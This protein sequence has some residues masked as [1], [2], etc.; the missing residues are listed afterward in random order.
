MVV[1]HAIAVIPASGEEIVDGPGKQ[2]DRP[3]KTVDL[4]QDTRSDQPALATITQLT[5]ISGERVGM[6]ESVIVPS[7]PT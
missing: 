6:M 2:H 4:S 7:A 5:W 1:G 3:V